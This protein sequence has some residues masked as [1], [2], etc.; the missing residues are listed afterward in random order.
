[1]LISS[2]DSIFS[3]HF[4]GRFPP[5][6]TAGWAGL[7]RGVA[8][9]SQAIEEQCGHCSVSKGKVPQPSQGRDRDLGSDLSQCQAPSIPNP[10]GFPS[11]SQGRQLC[12]RWA[13]ARTP[14][15]GQPDP[16]HSQIKQ[17]FWRWQ[18]HQPLPG[19]Q[20]LLT[21]PQ[22]Q[23]CSRAQECFYLVVNLYV[24]DY[25]LQVQINSMYYPKPI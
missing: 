14:F 17:D 11:R 1:M 18:R 7:W 8:D 15:C 21:S 2:P 23:F 24:L 10:K 22:H 16:S 9:E 25:I 13:P 6:A 12:P 3:A 4:R 19:W 20:T 5:I